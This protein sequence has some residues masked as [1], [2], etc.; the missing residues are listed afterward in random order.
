MQ[1]WADSLGKISYPLLSDFWPHGSVCEKYGVLRTADGYSER[2]IFVID[3]DGVIRYIDIHR[4]DEQPDNEVLRGVLRGLQ[5][6]PVVQAAP[7]QQED[8]IPSGGVVLYCARWCK[9]CK[10]VRAWLEAHH[11]EYVEVDIDYNLKARSQVRKWGN[12]AL[13]TPTIDVYGTIVLDYKEDKLE[14]ALRIA[15]QAGRV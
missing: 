11:L 2:A 4:I 12:G 6:G 15:Q 1:A 9:D 13:V 7:V 3:Q 8:E 14:E 10:R 5:T